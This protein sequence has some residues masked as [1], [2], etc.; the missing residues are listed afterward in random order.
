MPVGRF[1]AAG[2][3]VGLVEDGS[4]TPPTGRAAV[5]GLPGALTRP[6]GRVVVD[7]TLRSRGRVFSLDASL[8]ARFVASG[9]RDRFPSGF[10]AFGGDHSALCGFG[11]DFFAGSGAFVTARGFS[12]SSSFAGFSADAVFV[13]AG[14]FSGLVGD[15]CGVAVGTFFRS[16]SGAS[17]TSPLNSNAVP[18]GTTFECTVVVFA[19]ASSSAHARSARASASARSLANSRST[20][21]RIFAAS[22]SASLFAARSFSSRFALSVFARNRASSRAFASRLATRA[23]SS[24][25]VAR[26]ALARAM[27]SFRFAAHAAAALDAYRSR[28]DERAI[29]SPSSRSFARSSSSIRS[30]VRS[31]VRHRQGNKDAPRRDGRRDG[32]RHRDGRRPSRSSARPRLRTRRVD[33]RT[34]AASIAASSTADAGGRS[35][36]RSIRTSNEPVTVRVHGMRARPRRRVALERVTVDNGR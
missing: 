8:V 30:F 22:A 11:A 20:S 21:S 34:F 16:G 32:R 7:V 14:G 13:S 5:D 17:S 18:S 35:I 1:F 2:A 25:A 31:F 29:V 28:A 4:L 36:D 6:T 27:A 33:A 24:S 9:D 3:P 10:F 23:S 26:R 19:R 12:S 15:F